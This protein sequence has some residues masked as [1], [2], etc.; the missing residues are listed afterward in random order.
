MALALVIGGVGLGA[1]IE[2]VNAAEVKTVALLPFKINAAKDMSF[3]RDGIFDMFST[4][5]SKEGRVEV[6]DRKQTEDAIQAVAGSKT[7]NEDI[8][9]KI[10][11]NLNA[12][13]VVFGSLTVLGENVSIDTKLVDVS[14]GSPTQTFFDQAGDLGAVITKINLIAADINNILAGGKAVARKAGPAPSTPAP[15]PTAPVPGPAAQAPAAKDTKPDIHAHPEEMLKKGGYISK[16]AREDSPYIIATEEDPGRQLFWKSPAFKFGLVGVG[17]GDVDNDGKIETVV[18]SRSSILIYRMEKGR[19]FKVHEIPGRMN[20]SYLSLEVGDV[21][22][23]GYAEIYASGLNKNQTIA[24]SDVYEYNGQDFDLIA[25]SQPWLFRVAHFPGRGSILYGQGHHSSRPFK[26]RIHELNWTNPGYDPHRVVAAPRNTSIMG[27][28][29]GEIIDSSKETAAVISPANR[30][31]IVD[32]AGKVMWSSSDPYCATDLVYKT[33]KEDRTDVKNTFYFPMRILV[34]DTNGDGQQEV[35]AVQNRDIMGLVLTQQRKFTSTQIETFLWDGIGLRSIWKTR[36][37]DGFIRD[38][39]F[40]DFDN[41]GTDELIAALI[42][43]SGDMMLTKSKSAL[44]AYEI[45]EIRLPE[46][47]KE[48]TE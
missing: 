45:G 12:D 19:F 29:M 33:P 4:R 40:G 37:M 24:R 34:A 44:I 20:R 48:K 25:A 15:G 47:E 1:G 35:L 32:N 27:F 22:G 21:D 9:R 23:D 43:K 11:A 5:I 28:G 13:Y 31:R 30:I 38:L 46:K 41:D 36:K 14:G 2:P 8:A 42:I 16:G 6:L 18:L 3:L 26:D 7:V 39:A 10:G 17:V